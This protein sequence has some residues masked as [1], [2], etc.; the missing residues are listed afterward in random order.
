MRFVSKKGRQLDTHFYVRADGTRCLFLSKEELQEMV[1]SVGLVPEVLKYDARE[2][3]NRK[4]GITMRRVW[5]SARLRKPF[6]SS[7][8]SA[9]SNP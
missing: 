1:I 4:R 6:F 7:S 9:P 5:L 2:L 3:K 8:S